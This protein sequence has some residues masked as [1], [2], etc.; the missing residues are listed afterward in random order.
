M[1]CMNEVTRM[2]DQIQHGDPAQKSDG[3]R[4]LITTS[5]PKVAKGKTWDQWY[6]E[7]APSKNLEAAFRSK[8]GTAISWDEFRRRYLEEMQAQEE[9]VDGLVDLVAEGKTITLL[10]DTACFDA[11]YCHRTLLKVIVDEKVT[12]KAQA[13]PVKG[14][15]S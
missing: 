7:L 13:P 4:L 14:G 10:C 6:P 12:K 5:K 1:A 3:F 2:L 8:G 15:D 11:E 9:L